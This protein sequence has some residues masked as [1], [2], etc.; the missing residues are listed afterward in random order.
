MTEE[1]LVVGPS[2]PLT[3]LQKKLKSVL[4]QPKCSPHLSESG[5]AGAQK[6]AKAITTQLRWFSST[7]IR[8]A[9]CLGGNICTA[10]PISDMNPV[11]Q[12]TQATLTLSSRTED[13]QTVDR[14][15]PIR[16]F[17]LAYRKTALKPTEALTRIFIPMIKPFEYVQSYKQ[18]R[19]R[20]DDIAIVTSCFKVR[21]EPVP[22][23]NGEVKVVSWV[24]KGASMSFGGMAATTV[25]APLTEEYLI[26][27]PWSEATMDGAYEMLAKDLPLGEDA[28]GGQIE[29][30][31][32]LCSSFLFKYYLYVRQQIMSDPLSQP[33]LAGAS[34]E[35]SI[36]TIEKSVCEKD[37][38]RGVSTGTQVYQVPA[39]LKE[40]QH[41]GKPDMHLSG[42]L[43]VTGE[44]VYTDDIPDP[45][46]TVHCAVVWSTVA[47]A[48]IESVD[49]SEA[50]KM[51]GNPKYISHGDIIG[52]NT[53]GEIVKDE[54]VFVTK[55]VTSVGAMIGVI[56]ADTL[57]EAKA[58]ARKVKVSYQPLPNITTIDEAIASGSFMP[59]VHNI[60]DNDVDEALQTSDVLV[61]GEGRVPA[62]EHF[63][64][65]TQNSLVIPH[66]EHNE[67]TVW[68]STQ[69]PALT[70]EM[71]AHVLGI[72]N[73]RVNVKVKRMG[74]GFG[75]K[76]TR[77][78]NVTAVAAIVAGKL[79][80]PARL[81]LDRDEDIASSGQRHPFL[82]RFKAGFSKDGRIKGCD[83]K[84]FSN[85]GFS[86][87]L[88]LPVLDRG[89]FHVDNTY[90]FPA[91]RAE[92]RMCKTNL[93]SNTAY[94]GFGGPQGMMMAEFMMD[95]AAH[96]L[97]I[98]PEKLR[99]MNMYEEGDR[100]H[101]LQ[102]LD[103]CNIKRSQH[104]RSTTQFSIPCECA[105][106]GTLLTKR[107]SAYF[108]YLRRKTTH[109]QFV[110]SIGCGRS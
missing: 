93:P 94:R 31:R 97:N 53:A 1:G 78:G 12:A 95:K 108:T 57:K 6:L 55:E 8:N 37:Y 44:A 105:V 96:M 79:G 91:L 50:L 38:H 54:E 42:R 14:E 41:V 99:E 65:E 23:E 85:A 28:P 69:N 68:A 9:C 59:A 56:A 36:D 13:G 48:L 100:T 20:D 92:G 83:Y 51:P 74:G 52:H 58:A 84:L 10:S 62:Q 106:R 73:N 39:G 45:P 61:E 77:S 101:F 19:R 7:Q 87:D 81:C 86:H 107:R 110:V 64:L 90:K 104:E 3:Q 4:A 49:V 71:V 43:H 82:G 35:L 72:D 16:D 30:R 89:L 80:V 32:S 11:L 46:R 63:Y 17:F 47:H 26:G 67:Y 24:V 60:T 15:V 34:D 102:P 27:K 29:Y 103:N 75:G 109:Q 25:C 33:Y 70:Q 40:S 22:V 66:G 18:A 5:L 2:L 76:E 98:P 21:L 88:S